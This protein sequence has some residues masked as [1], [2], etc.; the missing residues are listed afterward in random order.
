MIAASGAGKTAC[1]TYPNI[2]YAC[3]CGMSFLV[4]DTK[5]DIY[6]NTA[7]TAEKYY[8]YA[9]GIIDL[10]NPIKSHGINM[11][12]LVNHYTDLYLKDGNLTHKAKAEKY[13]KITAKTIIYSTG[14]TD[15]G[16]NAYFYDTAESII[17][18]TILLLAEF[19]P[20]NTSHIISVYKLIQELIEPSK[21]IGVSNFKLF[22]DKLTPE[23]KARWF[24]GAALNSNEPQLL[25]VFSTALSRLNGFID[26][27]LEQILCFDSCINT[28]SFCRGKTA[29]YVVL[30][31]E[32]NTKHFL[33]SLIIQQMYR[34]ILLIADENGGKLNDC[35]MFYLEE[36]GTLPKIDNMEMIFSASRSRHVSIIANIQS[37]Q[38]L[39][40]KYGAEGADIIIDNC[41]NTITGGFAP[42]ATSAKTISE[43][44][45]KQTILSGSISRGNKNDSTSLQMI[46]K[47]LMSIEEL[48]TMPKFRFIVM[49]TGKHPMK[50][51]LKLFFKWGVT[52]EEQYE[53]KAQAERKIAYASKKEIEEAIIKN[54]LEIQKRNQQA[55]QQQK[56]A[57]EPQ[58]PP[59][60]KEQEPNNK[61]EPNP[62]D[63]KDEDFPLPGVKDDFKRQTRKGRDD[64]C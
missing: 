25:N 34:E 47:P 38:Q 57:E 50:T 7:T 42:N 15:F 8:G 39:R 48:K 5:G 45:G 30:P 10:R 26:S 2:E 27:E 35:V 37:F 1:F 23:H 60:P 9:I 29:L 59:E 52:F 16:Q 28:E 11:L 36:I 64:R 54:S 14:Q 58:N 41:Q 44:L 33:V 17:T 3:A 43:S 49:K 63:R 32:D 22:I 19:S 46:A 24:A 56:K 55:E 4:T 62:S 31:E 61:K 53:V 20:P 21:V 12:N 6:G 13:A 51:D 18:T 40:Q